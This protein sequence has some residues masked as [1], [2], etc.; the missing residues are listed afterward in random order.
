VA[1]A[2][3]GSE[4]A[5]AGIIGMIPL[6]RILDTVRGTVDEWRRVRWSELSFNEAPTATLVFVALLSTAALLLIARHL[7]R[8]APQRRHVAL[9][10]LL[11]VVRRSRLAFTRHAAFVL[12]VIGLPFFAV[13]LADPHTAFRRDDVSYVGRRIAM[14]VDSSTSMSLSFETTRLRTEGTP[15]FFTAV[16][17]A[18]RFMRQRM[19]GPYHD[20]IAL[21]QFGNE[22][23]VVT[24]FTTD[25]ENILLSLKLVSSPR[26]WGRFPDW[27]TTIIQGIDQGAALF[28]SFKYLNASGNL[29]L[30]FTDGRDDQLTLNGQHLDNMVREAQRTRIP[31]Y[32]IRTAH[33]L[34][35]G[36]VKQDAIWQPA[37]TRTGGRFYA[38]PDEASILKALDEIDRLSEGRI[39]IREYT[40]QRPRF[41]GYALIAVGLWLTAGTLK[42][43]LPFF[44]T[45]P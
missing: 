26:E 10:A 2:A 44:S 43:G 18:E 7:F 24:P 32:M 30:I 38:A 29:M 11:P 42:L 3:G 17:A 5:F 25:Y 8:P 31:M 36:E 13:A 1:A 6:A 37:I 12:F 22:A 45:F 4:S 40:T 14:L 41:S 34:K 21:I 27:G 28:R 39:D 23:Y 35:L 20:L 33:K 9:P 15:A 16:A 19:A